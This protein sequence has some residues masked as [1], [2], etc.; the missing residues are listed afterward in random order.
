M[1]F[2]L[3]PRPDAGRV[4][5]PKMLKPSM[6]AAVLA[7]TC[8]GVAHADGV[9][10]VQVTPAP[11]PLQV[12][13]G[14]TPR[15]HHTYSSIGAS[16]CGSAVHYGQV[17]EGAVVYSSSPAGGDAVRCSGNFVT[18]GPVVRTEVMPAY[19][20]TVQP[21]IYAAGTYPGTPA[22]PPLEG[23]ASDELYCKH[24]GCGHHG[25]P[26]HGKAH[27]KH[28]APRAGFD[29][30]FTGGVGAGVNGDWYGGGGIVVVPVGGRGYSSVMNHSAAAYT[31]KPRTVSRAPCRR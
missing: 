25:K 13:T 10:S 30:N 24:S 8:V 1:N 12:Q 5:G 26:H 28:S 19:V 27:H 17:R 16:P 6:I 11:A 9:N 29:G 7:M 3:T 31:M 23:G 15:V 22:H 21:I 4:T 2:K 14:A 18:T 20:E